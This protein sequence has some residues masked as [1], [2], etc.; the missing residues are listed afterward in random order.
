[1]NRDY[2]DHSM[3]SYQDLRRLCLDFAAAVGP[4]VFYEQERSSLMVSLQAFE[5]NETVRRCLDVVADRGFFAGH[6]QEHLRRVAVEAGTIVL[7]ERSGPA[8]GENKRKRLCFLAHVAGVLHDIKRSEPNHARVGAVEAG[9]ILKGFGF[10]D[11]EREMIVKAIANHEAFQ[12][13]EALS[14]PDGQLLSDAL[15]DADK[16]RWG[17]DNFTDT[18]WE[19]LALRKGENIPLL[20]KRFPR[21][22]EGIARIRE[23]FRTP[24][25][26]RYG[27]DFIDRGLEIGRRL[28]ARYLARQNGQGI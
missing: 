28:Y 14:D 12:A 21:G 20:F 13:H 27:P 18:L 3:N 15:Y 9:E 7:I 24:T 16:F 8:F 11:P 4:P 23:T 10:A 1:L 19:M 17:P 26:R 25:G 6:A 5:E 22:M 2:L